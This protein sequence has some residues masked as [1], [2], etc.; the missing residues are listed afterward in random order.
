[1]V[2]QPTGRGTINQKH[3]LSTTGNIP[4]RLPDRSIFFK[5]RKNEKMAH[6][7]PLDLGRRNV[8]A[9]PGGG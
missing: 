1:M 4:A 6:H 8:P 5:S 9:C 7:F 2:I 3:P